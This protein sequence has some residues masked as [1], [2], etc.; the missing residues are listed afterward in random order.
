MR[1]KKDCHRGNLFCQVS[2]LFT[3]AAIGIFSFHLVNEYRENVGGAVPWLLILL[4][5]LVHL[6]MHHG[7]GVRM[8]YSTRKMKRRVGYKTGKKTTQPTTRFHGA[9]K[10]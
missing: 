8:K 1:R 2:Q 3:L 9:I 10:H 7:Y 5:P 4:F 6:F